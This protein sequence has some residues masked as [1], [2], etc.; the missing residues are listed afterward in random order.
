[1]QTRH[2]TKHFEGKFKEQNLFIHSLEEEGLAYVWANFFLNLARS[3]KKPKGL[4]LGYFNH[5]S[6]C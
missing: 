6:V 2:L 1:M 5:Q 3:L 4:P